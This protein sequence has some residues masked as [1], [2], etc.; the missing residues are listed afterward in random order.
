[1]RRLLLGLVVA[2]AGCGE[3]GIEVTLAVS[4]ATPSSALTTATRLVVEVDGAERFSATLPLTDQLTVDRAARFVYR[5]S[6]ALGELSFLFTVG[7][8]Q[9]ALIASANATAR[10]PA[11]T[12]EATL[13]I[14]QP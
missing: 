9:G 14:S 8:D 1:M 4:P 7:D 11:T 6:V 10:L 12:V 5:P 13:Q 3:S 2:L